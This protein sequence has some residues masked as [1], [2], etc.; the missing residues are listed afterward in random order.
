MKKNGFTLIELLAIIVILAIIA[1]ITVPII[2]GIIDDAH[3]NAAKD[4]AYGYKDAVNKSYLTKLIGNSEYTVPDNKYTI[5]Q[6]KTEIGVSV[7]GKEPASNSW[8]RME[9][10]E[11]TAGCLQY[12]EYK[13]EIVDGEVTNAVKG[14][15]ETTP[16]IPSCPGCVFTFFEASF[17]EENNFKRIAGTEGANDTNSKLLEYTDDYREVKFTG[18]T[19]NTAF[20][21]GYVLDSNNYIRRSF[22]CAIYNDVPFCL[23]GGTTTNYNSNVN[24]MKSVFGQENCSGNLNEESAN[25][26]YCNKDYIYAQPKPSGYVRAGQGSMWESTH[27]ECYVYENGSSRCMSYGTSW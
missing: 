27:G 18:G 13:V 26:Y 16:T 23:E 19:Q 21:L 4:S 5:E 1:V 25:A 8:I 15:C 22:A 7:S 24:A 20:F 12:D 11:V 9:E 17:Y 2:L 10:N 14:E 6:L 3:M